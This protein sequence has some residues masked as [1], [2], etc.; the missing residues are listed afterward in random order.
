MRTLGLD[1]HSA[2][3]TLEVMTATGKVARQV[4]RDTTKQNLIEVIQAVS[5]PKILIV[6]ESHMAQW[7]KRTAEPYVDRLLIC[8]PQRNDWIAKDQFNDDSSSAHKLC[9]LHQGGF[10]KEIAHPGDD[11]A[12]LRRLFLHYYD[13]TQQLTCFKNKLKATFRQEAIPTSGAGIYD[14]ETHLAWLA[15]L[16]EQPHLRHIAAQRFTVVDELGDLKQDTYERM[17]RAARK[18]KAFKLLDGI[19]GAGPVIVTG[20]IALIETPHRFS[21]KNKLW[22]YAGFSN[23][24]K[25][26]DDVVYEHH[27]SKVGCRALKWVVL[28]HFMHAVEVS[29]KSN[30][31]KRQYEKLRAQGLDHSG[32]R[33]QVCRSQLSVVRAVWIKEEP[34]R[35]DPLN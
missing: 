27:A 25:T 26:S 10:L 2:T 24:E 30:R 6:E 19:P 9:V 31:F 20:Y 3:F 8:D 16:K 12:E 22:K 13:L 4:T 17:V 15:R 5:G 23:T 11:G 34:Y 33:R 14:R 28:E 32:A 7:V 1:A 29:V 21:R 35:D 18:E